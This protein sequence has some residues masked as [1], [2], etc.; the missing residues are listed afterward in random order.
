MAEYSG[1]SMLHESGVSNGLYYANRSIDD[2]ADERSHAGI[3]RTVHPALT[4]PERLAEG[5]GAIAAHH[6]YSAARLVRVRPSCVGMTNRPKGRGRQSRLEADGHMSIFAVRQNAWG[7]W[8]AGRKRGCQAVS[9]K[10]ASARYLSRADRVD[11]RDC[12][13]HG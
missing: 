1:M 4:G 9:V 5:D 12:F 13:T 6:G 11:L 3:A 7:T 2:A 10:S 8:R